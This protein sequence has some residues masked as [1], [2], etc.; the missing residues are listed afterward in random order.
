MQSAG[1]TTS[2]EIERLHQP[3]RRHQKRRVANPPS[4]RNNLSTTSE[5]GIVRYR[6]IKHPKF[7]V[8]DGL[9][10]ERSFSD[11]PAEALDDGFFAGGEELFVN[12]RRERVVE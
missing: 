1:A 5:N 10:A 8:S 4:G 12:F 7:A 6:S 11:A 2:V 3:R 9:I